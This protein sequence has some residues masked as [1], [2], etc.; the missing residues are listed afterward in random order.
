[1]GRKV[2]ICWLFLFPT[3][4]VIKLRFFV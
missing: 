1:M 2:A 3:S 4:N